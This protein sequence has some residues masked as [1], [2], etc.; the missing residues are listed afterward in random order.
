MYKKMTSMLKLAIAPLICGVPLPLYE[1]IK[2]M[3]LAKYNCC[4]ELLSF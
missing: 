4:H 3:V 1:L 2:E